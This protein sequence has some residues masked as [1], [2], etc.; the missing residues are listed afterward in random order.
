MT[1]PVSMPPATDREALDRAVAELVSR[2]AA[3]VATSASARLRIVDELIRDTAAVADRWIDL[4]IEAEG[5]DPETPASAEEGIV[6]PYF[7]LRYLRLLRRSLLDIERGGVPRIP[8][9]VTTRP[10]GR[11]VARVIPFDAWDRLFFLGQKADI[12]VPPGADGTPAPLTQA[13]AYRSRGAG[14]VCLVLGGGNVSSIGPLDALTKLFV[15][16]RVVILKTH[17]VNA[18]LAEVWQDAFAA[19][20]RPG[21]LRIVEGG[22]VEG[23]YLCHH[24]GVDE[25]HITG[26][27]RTYEAIVYG[28]GPEGHERKLRDEP[29]LHKPFT[30]ELGNVTPVIVVPG[31]WSAADMRYQADNVA[32]MLT[33]NAGFNCTAARVLVTHASWHGREDLLDGVRARLRATPARDAYYPGAAERFELFARA[34]P[35]AERYGQP[36]G[37]HLPWMLIPRL[38]PAAADDPCFTTEAFCGVFGEAALEAPDP[39]AFIERAVEFANERLWGTLSATLIVHPASLR[40]PRT[41]AALD[42]ALADLRYGTVSFN[43]WSSVGFGLG[44]TPWGAYPG[45]T[46]RD[47]QSGVGWVHD[48]LMFDRVE[49]T[50]ATAPFRV[51]PR[52]VWFSG[53]RTAHRLVRRLER[54]EA[55]PGLRHLPGI[56][57]LAVRG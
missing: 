38:D 40:D 1:P 46:R 6:G 2:R 36:G 37:R 5:L 57:I 9:P 44:V 35:E 12:W 53:H 30:A 16:D 28:A 51:W 17:P 32:T 29:L 41:R 48:T 39:A 4:S 34:H 55:K 31:P 20:I 24:T 7:T 52:P 56:G 11:T 23:G 54:F 47:I 3:W 15:E 50:V 10:D 26:S 25:L 43:H 19:L 27:D 49:K 21:F 22:A 45:H 42:R 8:G 14:A 33:N 18:Y 13:A